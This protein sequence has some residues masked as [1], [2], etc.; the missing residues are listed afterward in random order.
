M[1]APRSI[2]QFREAGFLTNFLALA[3]QRPGPDDGHQLL[4]GVL[5]IVVDDADADKTTDAIVKAAKT[6]KIGDG[7]IFVLDVES[8]LRVRTGETNDDA[9]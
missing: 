5:E 8:A 6:G 3:A 2:E 4:A 9:L 7:K 1:P